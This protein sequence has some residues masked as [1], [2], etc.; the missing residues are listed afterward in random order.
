LIFSKI[1]LK[2]F[3]NKTVKTNIQSII[4]SISMKKVISLS[5]G[6]L[7]SMMMMAQENMP[8]RP[9]GSMD[10]IPDRKWKNEKKANKNKMDTSMSNR[11][12]DTSMRKNT[13]PDTSSANANNYLPATPAMPKS[14]D[15]ATDLTRGTAAQGNRNA[16]DTFPAQGN[17]YNNTN[18]DTS[19]TTETSNAPTDRVM[20]IDEKVMVIRNG[21]STLLADKIE[22]ES[23]AIV[24]RDGTVTFKSGTTTKL[25]NGQFIN[26]NPADT[27]KEDK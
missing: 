20:M 16:S 6:V 18:A 12:S 17:T 23:G 13:W 21:D 10:T 15:T 1:G 11:W 3:K 4:K 19:T 5:A 7:F 14:N 8:A 2:A 22:L 27:K 26:L 24:T 25:K 9:N